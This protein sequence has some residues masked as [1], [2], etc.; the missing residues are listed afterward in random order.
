MST[1][2]SVG[3]LAFSDS[4]SRS[5][6]S[7]TV[8]ARSAL[9]PNER[10]MPTKSTGGSFSSMPTNVSVCSAAPRIA[11]TRCLRMR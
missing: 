9:I 10:A 3:A 7:F 2:I 6:A 5:V 11:S 1:S 8:F 4:A